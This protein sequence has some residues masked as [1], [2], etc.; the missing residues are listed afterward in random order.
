MNTVVHGG[1]GKGRGFLL[2][3]FSGALLCLPW[4]WPALFLCAWLAPVPLLW[5]LSQAGPGRAF[6]LGW[7]AGSVCFAGASYWLIDFVMHLHAVSWLVA[8]LLS[9]LFWVY[10][11]LVLAF[12]CLLARLLDRVLSGWQFVTF[13]LSVVVCMQLFP[14]LFE[15]RFAEAQSGFLLALQGVD[16]IGAQGLD[17]IM[18]MT[19]SLLYQALLARAVRPFWSSPAL[20]GWA[21]LLAWFT[22]SGL[23]W[24]HWEREIAGW[25]V[26]RV[27]LVQPNDAPS[28]GLPPVPAGFSREQ[29]VEMLASRQL[30]AQGAELLVW[31]EARY[32]GYFDHDSVRRAWAEEVASWQVPLLF[33][34]VE[35]L[36][37]GRQH[38]VFNTL[39]LLNARGRRAGSYRKMQPMPFGEYLPA[40]FSWPGLDY[41]SRHFLGDFLRP[42]AAGN[43]HGLFFLDDILLVPKICYETAFPLAVADAIGADA[44]GKVL[45]FASQNSWFGETRQPFQHRDMSI[46]RGIENRV[47][48]I[49]AI[50]NGPSVVASPTGRILAS[51][52]AFRQAALLAEMPFSAASGGSFFSRYPALFGRFAQG[53][54]LA[55]LALA[56]VLY[57]RQR[58]LRQRRR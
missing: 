16:L 43:Q 25:S 52:P 8:L 51:T 23:A 11:G 28:T 47:P 14:L 29:P 22:Y 49:H 6:C 1:R 39:A 41:L 33:H 37:H 38:Q 13:P 7:L 42:L 48:V 24:L 34:D 15:T 36:E 12:A 26:K 58:P 32:K 17:F 53:L 4:L 54:L 3:A 9:V 55:L 27:G 46:V 35:T 31:P 18:L 57:W 45:V 19:G 20:L 40:V 2:A 44:A 30:V 56:T 50:N 5:A 10:A 21:L